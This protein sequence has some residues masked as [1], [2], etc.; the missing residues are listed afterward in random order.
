VKDC[1][2]IHVLEHG[3]V[4]ASGSYGELME[5]CDIFRAMAQA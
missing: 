3:K 4:V 5:N 1:D 2:V